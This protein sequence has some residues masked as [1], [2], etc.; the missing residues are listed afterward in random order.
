M[1]GESATALVRGC[2]SRAR[3]AAR[4]S[5][6]SGPSSGIRRGLIRSLSV[7]LADGPPHRPVVPLDQ[8]S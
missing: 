3:T 7:G 5:L 8:T 2:G 6:A 1:A 4:H